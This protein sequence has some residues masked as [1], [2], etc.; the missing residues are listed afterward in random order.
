[1]SET[2]R[3]GQKIVNWL[4]VENRTILDLMPFLERPIAEFTRKL[5]YMSDEEFD[6]LFGDNK[7]CVSSSSKESQ[8]QS[9]EH[10][11]SIRN[12]NV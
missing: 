9:C 5:F 1:M 11:Q 12:V 4:Y 8:Q 3:K 7:E 2:L 10:K 6:T